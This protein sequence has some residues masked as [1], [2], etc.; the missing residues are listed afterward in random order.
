MDLVNSIVE[1]VTSDADHALTLGVVFL[2]AL[3]GSYAASR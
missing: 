1:W 3:V 2:F